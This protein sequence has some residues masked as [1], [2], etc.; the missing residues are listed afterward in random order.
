MDDLSG[1]SLRARDGSSVVGDDGRAV[2]LV[3]GYA[4]LPEV[5][6]DHDVRGQL[7]PLGRDPGVVHLEYHGSIRVRD[8]TGSLFP[9][10]GVEDVLSLGR[11]SSL[12]VHLV[13]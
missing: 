11:E 6:A 2:I 10:N 13:P 1:G 4:G 3:L 12:Y 7:A 8:S 9:F 5:F